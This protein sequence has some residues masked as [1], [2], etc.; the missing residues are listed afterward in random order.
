MTNIQS[1]KLVISAADDRLF[2]FLSNFNNFG[3]IMPGQVANWKSTETECSFTIQGMAD[4]VLNIVEKQ[5]NSFIRIAAS[6]KTPIPLEMHWSFK[7]LNETQ[8]ET[9]LSIEADINPMMAMMVKS[10]LQN[11]VNMIVAKL[12]E[13]AETGML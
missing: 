12:K 5:P 13:M 4:I 7:S 9:M 1:D 6:G 11:F 2:S 10:P 3:R 8:T